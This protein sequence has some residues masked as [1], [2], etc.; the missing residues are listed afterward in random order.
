MKGRH[1]R[2]GATVD[3]L[4]DVHGDKHLVQYEKHWVASQSICGKVKE[5]GG[6]DPNAPSP[7]VT[8]AEPAKGELTLAGPAST[9]KK[10]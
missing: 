3:D 8:V 4:E 2:D 9:E 1:I 7:K 6:I 5:E 10:G